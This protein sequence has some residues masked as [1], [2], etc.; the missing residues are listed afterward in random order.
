VFQIQV[1]AEDPGH[2]TQLD[3]LCAPDPKR[4]KLNS[5]MDEINSRY[6]EFSIAPLSMQARS[7]MPN[8]I[9]PAWKPEGHRQ[10]I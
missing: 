5:V 6:G 7:M 2:V 4:Q 1:T 3:L 10:T 9:A 8:V